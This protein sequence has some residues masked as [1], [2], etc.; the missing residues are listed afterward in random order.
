[1]SQNNLQNDKNNKKKGLTVEDGFKTAHFTRIIKAL[2]FLFLIVNCVG[3]FLLVL[4]D[5]FKGNLLTTHTN[6]CYTYL[7]AV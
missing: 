7:V 5:I 3:F 6:I 4:D 1:M 2:E